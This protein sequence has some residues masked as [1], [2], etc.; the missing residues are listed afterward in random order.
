MDR[1]DLCRETTRRRQ[2]DTVN[3][4]SDSVIFLGQLAGWARGL[5]ISS[6][7]RPNER[8]FSHR[9]IGGLVA[10]GAGGAQSRRWSL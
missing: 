5:S 8:P 3:T 6:Q 4:R 7:R 10:R 2:R 9:D 1:R